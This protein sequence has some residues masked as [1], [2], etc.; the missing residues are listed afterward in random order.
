M[1]CDVIDGISNYCIDFNLR[2]HTIFRGT[3][4]PTSVDASLA[5]KELQ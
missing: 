5:G 1:L 4:S 2:K 3:S